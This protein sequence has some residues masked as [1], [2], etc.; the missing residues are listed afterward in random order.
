[1][2]LLYIIH[3]LGFSE[4]TGIGGADKRV[5][6]IGRRLSQKGAEIQV[7]TTNAGHHVL[8]EEGLVAKYYVICP[9]FWWFPPMARSLL[10]RAISYIYSTIK[11]LGASLDLKNFS[12]VY[13]SS[14]FF[15]DILP[16]IKLKRKQAHLK[17]AA[18]IH[19]RIENPMK[20]SGSY[21]INCLLYVLQR[22]SFRLLRANADM[23]FVYA[24]AEGRGIKEYLR[25]MGFP[26]DRIAEV[27]NGVDYQHIDQIEE[28]E[29]L[30]D[31]CFV[32]GLRP[33]KGIYDLVPIWE[34]LCLEKKNSKL[35]VIG[36]GAERYRCDIQREVRE[37]GLEHN[38]TMAGPL[39]G[40]ALFRAIKSCKISISTSHE[41]GWGIAVCEAMSCGLPVVAYDLSAYE[42][43]GTAIIRVPKGQIEDFVQAILRLMLDQELRKQQGRIAKITASRFDWSKAAEVELAI[44]TEMTKANR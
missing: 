37:K 24:S 38:I 22:I 39:S 27:N 28:Q 9:P 33:S 18:M 31:A 15:F 23:I 29:K 12:I 13:A 41:E 6:E 3:G 2:R 42:I 4:K 7:L 26:G 30:Y 16:A 19:H 8:T 10:G 5:V 17:M 20:R 11:A 14:D 44:L 25:G 40:D 36:G 43:F 21:F 35:L 1:M 32:G 34:Q